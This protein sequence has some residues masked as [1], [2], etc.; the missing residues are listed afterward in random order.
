MRQPSFLRLFGQELASEQ[1]LFLAC[2]RRIHDR[3]RE[4][5]AAEHAR[6]FQR[7]GQARGVV[8]GARRIGRGIHDVADPRIDV[9]A[10]DHVAVR[11]GGA[12]LDGDHADDLGRPGDTRFA[13]HGA[14]DVAHLQAPAAV[15]EMRSNSACTQ[16]RA[17][18]MPRVFEVVSDSVWRV[19]KP[20]RVRTSRSIRVA[21]GALPMAS[22]SAFDAGGGVSSA[23][24]GPVTRQER[25]ARPKSVRVMRRMRT[26]GYGG[27][28]QISAMA[29]RGQQATHFPGASHQCNPRH[30]ASLLECRTLQSMVNND[31]DAIAA[32]RIP[33]P[34][35]S[36]AAAVMSRLF[37]PLQLGPLQLPNRILIA[38]MCQ[39]SSVNGLACD[40]HQQHWTSLA[41]SG[42]GLLITEAAA[43]EPRGR[44][45]WGDLGLYDDATEAAFAQALASVRRW[46]PMPVG[47]Q[48]AHA[49]RKASTEKPWENG[50]GVIAP[51]AEHGWQVV[52]PSALPYAEGQPMPEALDEVGIAGIVCNFV[53]SAQRAVRLGLES[54]RVACRPRVPVAPVPVAAQQP[55]HGSLWRVTRQPHAAG[56]GGVRCRE[57]GGAGVDGAGHPHLRHRLGRGWLG[58]R[59]EHCAG[60]GNSTRVVAIT[61]MCPVLACIRRRRSRSVRATSCRSPRRSSARWR[62]RWSRSA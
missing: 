42:A 61:S 40:W 51:D 34:R 60:Q 41:L 39:Y 14:A 4:A 62:C 48:L 17:A 3:P 26:P 25:I 27:S 13:L 50:G 54:D 7:A 57:S 6:G 53:D 1:A 20:T 43:V 56:A 23:K 52:A 16:R 24:A 45:S 36:P 19:P 35:R 5:V 11:V 28:V 59:P 46:S 58:S 8:I 10:H 44:I 33:C 30:T 2:K 12:A 21:D 37:S 22:S 31:A 38:P 55:P 9:A 32:C 15:R 49:G 29:R 18:P 47:V